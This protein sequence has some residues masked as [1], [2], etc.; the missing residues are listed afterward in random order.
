MTF[1]TES[2]PVATLELAPIREREASAPEGIRPHQD[3][4]LVPSLPCNALVRSSAPDDPTAMDAETTPPSAASTSGEEKA[5]APEPD[6]GE[7]QP[8]GSA[9]GWTKRTERV[10]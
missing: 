4:T 1:A 10:K 7:Q 9:T 8:A 6:A 3:G 5:V 2:R